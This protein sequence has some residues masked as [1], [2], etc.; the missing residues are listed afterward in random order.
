MLANPHTVVWASICVGPWQ[1]YT[2]KQADFA[3]YS[4]SRADLNRV[5]FFFGANMKLTHVDFDKNNTW[6]PKDY[7]VISCVIKSCLPS[8]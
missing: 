7:S 4:E 6:I 2:G 8:I 5:E 3:H 1:S